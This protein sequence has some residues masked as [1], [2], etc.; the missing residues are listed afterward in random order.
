M[1]KKGNMQ[2]TLRKLCFVYYANY[3]MSAMQMKTALCKKY[4]IYNTNYNVEK[5][6]K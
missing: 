6:Q 5:M 4:T 1:G 2:N 3:I